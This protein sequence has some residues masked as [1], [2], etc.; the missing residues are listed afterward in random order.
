MAV[1]TNDITGDKI[2]SKINSK[3]YQDNFDLIVFE[4]DKPKMVELAKETTDD[5]SDS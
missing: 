4:R 3:A 2:S 5:T 1:A